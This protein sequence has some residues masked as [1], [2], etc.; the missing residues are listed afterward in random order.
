MVLF[1]CIIRYYQ[2][3][4]RII[5]I[6]TFFLKLQ[7]YTVHC[8]MYPGTSAHCLDQVDPSSNPNQI[9]SGFRLEEVEEVEEVAQVAQVAEM[10]CPEVLQSSQRCC[11]AEVA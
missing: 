6:C 1:I 10:P 9:R 4:W 7:L 2:L 5:Y 8:T 11:H 3:F